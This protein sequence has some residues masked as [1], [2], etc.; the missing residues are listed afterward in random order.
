VHAW[1]KLPILLGGGSTIDF[2]SPMRQVFRHMRRLERDPRV[3]TASLFMVHPYTS[4]D[5]L[6]WAVHVSTDGDARLAEKTVDALADRVWAERD[7]ALPPMR[8][9]ADAVAEVSRSPW[10]HLGPVS[11]VDV[12]DIVGAGAPGGNTRILRAILASG[13]ALRAYVPLHDPAAID[14][15]WSRDVGAR[16]S[17]MLRGTPGYAQPEVPAAG[18]VAAKRVTDFGRTVRLDVGGVSV[19]ISERPPLP[20]HPKF[21]RELGLDPRKADCIVQKNFFH[22][23]IFY[24]AS[25]FAHI[26][27]V[28]EG[29][30]S[31]VL[32]RARAEAEMK[33]SDIPT[34]EWRTADPRLRAKPRRHDMEAARSKTPDE[35]SELEVQP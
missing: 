9:A 5:D 15:L 22:Y 1:R 33:R 4:A 10:R 31:L 8:S 17:Q 35:G 27:V 19:V 24:A 13:D 21:W 23:R 7:V 25:S 18:T 11:L 2:L 16:V 34:S 20:V 29:A 14:A 30:T 6:G 3:L 26:P 28:T 12:D 32:A